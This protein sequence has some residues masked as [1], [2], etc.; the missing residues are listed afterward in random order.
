MMFDLV[1][2]QMELRRLQRRR[3]RSRRRYQ[4]KIREARKQGEPETEIE[5]MIREDMML[6]DRYDDDIAQ[7]QHRVVVRQAEHFLIPTSHYI[8]DDGTWVQ[9][10]VTGQWR[11]SQ[12]KMLEIRQDI[13]QERRLRR[14]HWQGWL[15]AVTGFVGALI[16]LLSIFW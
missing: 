12:E 10:T 16:G 8:K 15:A 14:E 7:L 3:Q 9:S 5:D 4:K 11:Y 13:W 2:M 6:D 1:S